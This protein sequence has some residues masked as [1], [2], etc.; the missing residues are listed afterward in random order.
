MD[1]LTFIATM[2]GHIMWPLVIVVLLFLLRKHIGALADR[3][4]EFS[5]GGAKFVWK[6][7]LAEGAIIIEHEPQPELTPPN[8]QPQSKDEKR[9]KIAKG[10][11]RR[12]EMRRQLLINSAF[13]KVLSGLDEVDKVLFEIADGM[14]FDPASAS[15]VMYSLVGHGNVPPSIGKLYDTLRDARNL[16]AHSPSLPDEKEANEYLRQT[17]YLMSVLENFRQIM[18][19]RAERANNSGD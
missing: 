17:H 13:G 8:K 19:T 1:S 3:I 7:K 15:S 14:G 9:E 4:E 16:I 18:P 12:R 11:I 2:T 5:F 6:K 10:I